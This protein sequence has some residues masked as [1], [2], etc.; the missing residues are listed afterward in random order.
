MESPA[1]E[2]PPRGESCHAAMRKRMSDST[3]HFDYSNPSVRFR[4]IT[5]AWRPLLPVPACEAV[6]ESG[7]HGGEALSATTGRKQLFDAVAQVD[8]RLTA[9]LRSI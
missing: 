4:P 6:L 5:S 9:H 2:R 3:R 7:R 8:G 1:A